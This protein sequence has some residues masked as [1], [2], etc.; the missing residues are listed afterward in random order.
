MFALVKSTLL[1]VVSQTCLL[2]AASLVWGAGDTC[3]PDWK[4]VD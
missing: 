3:A 4:Q 1:N 2:A